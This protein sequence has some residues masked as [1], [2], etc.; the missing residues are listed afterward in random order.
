MIITAERL[1]KPEV[2][3]NAEREAKAIS[4]YEKRI[5]NEAPSFNPKYFDPDEYKKVLTW[6]ARYGLH[7]ADKIDGKEE[8]YPKPER[9]LLIN[10][11]TGRGKSTLA[12]IISMLFSRYYDDGIQFY[13][14]SEIDRAWAMNPSKCEYDYSEVF[15]MTHPVIIDDVG[16]EGQIKHFGN[17]PVFT[18]LMPKLYDAWKYWGKLVIV[19]SNLS[20]Y[21]APEMAKD[22]R[23]F[24]GVYGDRTNSRIHEM[25]EIVRINGNEDLRKIQPTEPKI[26]FSEV[27]SKSAETQTA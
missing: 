23:T 7:V 26:K 24:L 25:F 2:K 3:R 12:G 27:E 8:V 22:D 1:F 4:H 15:D 17:E 18:F 20:T 13:S 6:I 11:R 5:A 14:L 10:G 9:G 21:D 19:T 16:A